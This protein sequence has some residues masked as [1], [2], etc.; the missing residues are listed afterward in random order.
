MAGMFVF[1]TP[2]Q[3]FFN[4]NNKSIN[5]VPKIQRQT[6]IAHKAISAHF[7]GSDAGSLFIP[8]INSNFLG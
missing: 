5:G 1:H 3:S 7:R 4:F 6:E 8:W 2:F